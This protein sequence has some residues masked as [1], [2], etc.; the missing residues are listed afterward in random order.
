MMKNI[1]KALSILLALITC[2]STFSIFAS[3]TSDTTEYPA[4]Y[5]SVDEGYVTSVK[6]QSGGT[7]WAFAATAALEIDA[8]KQGYFTREE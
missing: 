2:V 7:C 4:Y 8:V 5:S 6:C 3:A 1:T